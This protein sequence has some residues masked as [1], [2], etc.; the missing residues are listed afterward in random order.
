MPDDGADE[1]PLNAKGLPPI[2]RIKMPEEAKI[3]STKIRW[4]AGVGYEVKE[5]AGFL[6]VRYQQV[7]NVL[8]NPPK[9]MARE[10]VP[11]LVVEIL[12]ITDDNHEHMDQYF[13]ERE[14]AAQRKESRD[15]QRKTN[16]KRRALTEDDVGNEALDDENYQGE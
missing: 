5:I 13:L 11:P 14:M 12:A 4:L 9:R 16:R 15:A 8:T 7:R 1:V 3:T 2:S 10:D 6:G